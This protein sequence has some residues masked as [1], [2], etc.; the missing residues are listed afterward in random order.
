MFEPI[1]RSSQERIGETYKVYHHVFDPTGA[2]YVTKG[3]G[4]LFPHHRGLFFGFNRISYGDGGSQKADIWHCKNGEHQHHRELLAAIGGPAFGRETTRIDW[5][6]R[7][8]K[9]FA[10]ESREMTAYHVDGGLLIEFACVLESKAGKVRLDGDPQHAGFQFRASQHVPDKTKSQTYYVRPDGK[11]EPG[12]FRNWSSK[13]DESKQN[14]AHIDFG[15]ECTVLR[16]RWPALHVLLP[17][18]SQQPKARQIQRTRL[19]SIRFV[20]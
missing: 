7:D 2:F 10:E 3:P 18:S 6:G 14:L 20:F 11:G 15:L 19:W 4:G 1:D 13:K 16:D 12:K 9:I 17:R 8:D 5:H